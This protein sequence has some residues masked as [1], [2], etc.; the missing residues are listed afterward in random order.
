MD[1]IMD[2]A[3]LHGLA[4]VE[5]VAHAPGAAYRGKKLGTIGDVGCF[6][7]F[8]NKNM[9]TGE[10]GMI[11]TDNDDLA[12]KIR[13]LRSHGMTTLTLDRHKGHA[14]SYDVLDLGYNYRIDEIRA[15]IGIEQLKKLEKNNEARKNIVSL[16]RNFLQDIAEVTIP[17]SNDVDEPAFHIFPILLEPNIDIELFRKKLREKGI[18]TSVHYPPIHLFTFYRQRFGYQEGLL[19]ITEAIA[20]REV[21]LPLYPQMEPSAVAYIVDEIKNALYTK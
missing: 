3:R 4:V 13:L 10:G 7:F 1:E 8:S 6:S 14:H 19:P 18:Q 11:V 15:A 2:I 5:D 21:T 9:T 12:E 20:K 17:F 16:Y